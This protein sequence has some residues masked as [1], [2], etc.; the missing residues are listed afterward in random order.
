MSFPRKRKS[1]VVDPHFR[2]DD[3][4]GRNDY[5]FRTRRSFAD[6]SGLNARRAHPNSFHCSIPDDGF[7]PLKIREK[8]TGKSSMAKHGMQYLRDVTKNYYRSDS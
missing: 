8:P 2:G 5:G 3:R 6:L 7:D 1:Q 4:L